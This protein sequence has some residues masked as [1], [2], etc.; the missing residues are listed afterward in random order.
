MRKTI[1]QGKKMPILDL[2]ETKTPEEEYR[3]KDRREY[4]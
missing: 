4:K 2:N 1:T 3:G